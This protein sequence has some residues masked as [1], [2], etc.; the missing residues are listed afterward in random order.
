MIITE[1][2]KQTVHQERFDLTADRMPFRKR[3]SV[4]LRYGNYDIAENMR[5]YLGE[6]G[7]AERKR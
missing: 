3:L 5:M 6:Q 2:V 1:Q 4:C 7:S